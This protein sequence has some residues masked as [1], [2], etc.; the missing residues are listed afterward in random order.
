MEN[1][2]KTLSKEEFRNLPAQVTHP[3]N[4]RD[5]HRRDLFCERTLPTIPQKNKPCRS[6]EP[7]VVNLGR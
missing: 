4:L 5:D 6:G 1:R 2:S 7:G 3:G